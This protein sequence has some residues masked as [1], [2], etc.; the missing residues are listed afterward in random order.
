M[1]HYHLFIHQQNCR[2]FDLNFVY[3]INN[4]NN[5]NIHRNRSYIRDAIHY[6]AACANGDDANGPHVPLLRVQDDITKTHEQLCLNSYFI[7]HY[8]LWY[9][10]L[11]M[12]N[13]SNFSS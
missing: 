8:D 3:F 13:Y 1:D 10:I 2:Y 12:S 6:T 9:F 5:I 7:F 4:I 11:Y